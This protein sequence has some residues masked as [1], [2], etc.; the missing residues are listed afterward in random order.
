MVL[1]A[2]KDLKK[3]TTVKV[4]TVQDEKYEE[5]VRFCYMLAKA[6]TI[7]DIVDAYQELKYDE[8]KKLLY[9]SICCK[10]T[11]AVKDKQ[12]GAFKT[13]KVEEA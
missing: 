7:K 2:I 13:D 3:F 12:A 4:E 6:R 1:E 11:D 9:C 8:E 5:E 10:Y